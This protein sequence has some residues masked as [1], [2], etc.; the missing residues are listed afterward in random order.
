MTTLTDPFTPS[1]IDNV[2]RGTDFVGAESEPVD[3]FGN[4]FDDTMH[5]RNDDGTP[6]LTNDGFL[7]RRKG[8]RKAATGPAGPTLRMSVSPSPTGRKGSAGVDYRPGLLG[9]GQ[10]G[11]TVLAFVSPLD[12]LAV[13]DHWPGI[14]EALNETAKTNPALA[15]I[16][17][18]VLAMGPWGLVIGACV[19]LAV[20]VLANH[21]L[22]PEQA[23][24]GLGALTRE[25]MVARLAAVVPA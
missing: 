3:R 17:D 7:Y 10:M 18:K 11:A 13:T 14:A 8:P 5:L 23:T 1:G 22:L 12:A 6:R 20:Q 15:G 21:K 4:T 19:P 25:Q 2:S 16:L 24:T 9:V